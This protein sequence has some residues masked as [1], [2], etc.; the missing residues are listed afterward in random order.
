[1]KLHWMVAIVLCLALTAVS[2]AQNEFAAYNPRALAMGTATAG[3]ADDAFAWLDNPAGLA[4][5]NVPVAEGNT[6]GN[7]ILGSYLHVSANS[8]SDNAWGVNWSGWMPERH[9]GAGAG[10]LDGSGGSKIYGAGFGMGLGDSGL[11]VGVNALIL[12]DSSSETIFNAGLLYQIKQTNAQPLRI[13]LR[14]WD[15]TDKF[16]DGTWF[17][18]GIGWRPTPQLLVAIDANDITDQFDNGVT[19]S[20]GVEYALT[21]TGEWK[22]RAG[23]LDTGDTT[24]PTFG[25][26]YAKDTWR[27]DAA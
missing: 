11:S 12:D 13:G 6:W 21:Q 4:A 26:G 8:S 19:V 14:A 1:M 3:V 9:L 16:G 24:K 2:H 20:G 7:D 25:L 17:D 27:I 23:I 15:L 10:Y 5:L 18:L 22:V